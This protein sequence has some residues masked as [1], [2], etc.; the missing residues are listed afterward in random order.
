MPD[1]AAFAGALS[2]M[3]A[4]SGSPRRLMRTMRRVVDADGE[5][6]AEE[7]AFVTEIEGHLRSAG[8]L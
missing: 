7:V 8:R 4:G 6:D 2:R 5:V 3:C 1:E